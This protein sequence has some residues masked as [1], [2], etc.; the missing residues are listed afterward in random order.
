MCCRVLLD[1][2]NEFRF[3]VTAPSGGLLTTMYAANR[4]SVRPG[5]P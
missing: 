2:H 1:T 4:E 3:A 5:Q